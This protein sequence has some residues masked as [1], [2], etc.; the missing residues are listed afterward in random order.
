MMKVDNITKS[1][2]NNTVL[3]GITYNFEKGNITTI[4]APNGSGKT[5]LLS[6]ISGLL[7]PDS[8]T[9]HFYEN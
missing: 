8:G 5:T 2:G 1:Y 9:V 3:R 7:I 6:I 4:L